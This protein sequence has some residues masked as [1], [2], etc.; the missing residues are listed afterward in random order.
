MYSYEINS[1]LQ[2]KNFILDNFYD[3][4][5]IRITS[6]QISNYTLIGEREGLCQLEVNT[7]DNFTWYIY[8]KTIRTN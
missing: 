2:D 5:K 6:P 8:I 7:T 3:F 4:E 1:Y